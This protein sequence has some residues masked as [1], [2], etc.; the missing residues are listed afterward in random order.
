MSRKYA[1]LGQRTVGHTPDH[2]AEEIMRGKN[3]NKRVHGR[4][5]VVHKLRVRE[6]I[7]S[8]HTKSTPKVRKYGYRGLEENGVTTY[9]G[10]QTGQ[11]IRKI[12]T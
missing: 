9:M 12:R 8:F 11:V 2:H 10:H 7:F 4:E 6:T 5:Q 3:T 1:G